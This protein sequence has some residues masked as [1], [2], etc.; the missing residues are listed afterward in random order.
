MRVKDIEIKLQKAIAL[1]HLYFEQECIAHEI[2]YIHGDAEDAWL[3]QSPA[4]ILCI[5]PQ[6][7]IEYLMQ[8]EKGNTLMDGQVSLLQQTIEKAFEYEETFKVKRPDG[9]NK[10]Y[11]SYPH[12]NFVLW[13]TCS[14]CNKDESK[15]EIL[16]YEIAV[17]SNFGRALFEVFGKPKI[18][19]LR[20]MANCGKNRHEFYSVFFSK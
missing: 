9:F 3:S 8:N 1:G 20:D 4:P 18:S 19:V 17:S 10:G 2:E 6:A 14:R 16:Y 5:S 7:I 11:T 12:T 13:G 15:K